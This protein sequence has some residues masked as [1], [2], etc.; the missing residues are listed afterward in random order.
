MNKKL[1]QLPIVNI[2]G[3]KLRIIEMGK[4][5]GHISF[6]PANFTN[7]PNGSQP[8]VF[9]T[10][11]LLPGIA[12]NENSSALS[13]RGSENDENLVLLDGFTLYNL[14]HFFG[15]FSTINPNYIKDIQI[16]KGGFDSRYGERVSAIIDITGKS[17]SQNNV[18]ANG[19]INLIS[20][21]L[22]IEIPLGKKTTWIA[23]GRKTYYNLFNS[24]LFKDIFKNRFFAD[25]KR[26][27]PKNAVELTPNYYFYDVNTKISHQINDKEKITFSAFASKDFLDLS[28]SSQNLLDTIETQN[29]NKWEN[30]GISSS[31][32]KQWNNGLYS[33][34]TVG[35]SG[36]SN[37]FFDST[38]VTHYVPIINPNPNLPNRVNNFQTNEGN[39]LTDLFLALKSS[40]L[41]NNN[42]RIDFGFLTRKNEF[43]FEKK[44]DGQYLYNNLKNSAVLSSIFVQDQY[45]IFR[46]L[47][48]KPGFRLNHY[49]L[50]RKLYFEPRLSASYQINETI[51]LKMAAGKYF[52]FLNKVSTDQQYGYNRDFWILSDESRHPIIESDHFILGTNL[53]FGNFL[54]DVEAYYKTTHGIQEY[55][56]ISNYQRGTIPDFNNPLQVTNKFVVGNGNAMGLDAML[57]FESRLYTGWISYT[58]SKS[59]YHFQAINKNE[60]IPALFDQPHKFTFVNLISWRKWNFSALYIFASGQPY[61]SKQDQDTQFNIQRTYSRLPNYNRIDI[62]ANYNLS[63][64]KLNIKMGATIINLLNFSN[65]YSIYTRKFDFQNNSFTQTSIIKAQG[66]TP[67]V[68]LE[69]NF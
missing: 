60:E 22:G 41:F 55:F 38:K 35:Y 13:I 21:N 24:P 19:G 42:H 46:G 14:D 54:F 47:T 25:A 4:D 3:E 40:Y 56:A 31:W 64:K 5:A 61:I 44:S 9:A 63:I 62:S 43:S 65:Y 7:L 37:T 39:E 26:N 51:G 28:N 12:S 17:G 6:N 36:Y 66:L 2:T 34:L 58:R 49:E 59:Y 32:S 8:D 11:Q 57:K 48:I 29:V 16:Y 52:Q 1:V 30:Y 50:T 23:T 27:P 68:F 10:L 45:T 15:Q 53:T 67:N 69:F 33:L 20:S 18:K